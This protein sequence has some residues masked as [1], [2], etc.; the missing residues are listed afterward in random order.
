MLSHRFTNTSVLSFVKRRYSLTPKAFFAAKTNRPPPS[1]SDDNNPSEGAFLIRNPI[2]LIKTLFKRLTSEEI[3]ELHRSLRLL[4]T[5]PSTQK[6]YIEDLEKSLQQAKFALDKN[7]TNHDQKVNINKHSLD[8]LWFQAWL[9][10]VLTPQLPTSFSLKEYDFLPDQQ[11]Q[12][13]LKSTRSKKSKKQMISDEDMKVFPV[14]GTLQ[15]IEKEKA[16][17][18]QARLSAILFDFNAFQDTAFRKSIRK[19]FISDGNDSTTTGATS[20]AANTSNTTSADEIPPPSNEELA[21]YKKATDTTISLF[22]KLTYPKFFQLLQIVEKSWKIKRTHEERVYD[23]DHHT[24]PPTDGTIDTIPTPTTISTRSHSIEL[25]KSI[26]FNMKYDYD[27]CAYILME[28][29]DLTNHELKDYY[30]FTQLKNYKSLIFNELI[31][32]IFH[33]SSQYAL[34]K[35]EIMLQQREMKLTTSSSSSVVSAKSMDI[36]IPSVHEIMN[37]DVDKPVYQRNDETQIDSNHSYKQNDSHGDNRSQKNE[38]AANRLLHNQNFYYKNYILGRRGTFF[39]RQ[40]HF[41]SNYIFEVELQ[42]FNR[43]KSRIGLNY[44]YDTNTNNMLA[45]T[46]SFGLRSNLIDPYTMRTTEGSTRRTY[47]AFNDVMNTSYKDQHDNKV[48]PEIRFLPSS[49]SYKKVLIDNLPPTITVEE[50]KLKLLNFRDLNKNYDT[51][52]NNGL[53][54]MDVEIEIFHNVPKNMNITSSKHASKQV[55]VLKE[56]KTMSDKIDNFGVLSEENLHEDDIEIDN[57]NDEISSEA[58]LDSV[59]QNE[60]RLPEE[61]QLRKLKKMTMIEREALNNTNT[62]NISHSNSAP[63]PPLSSMSDVKKYSNLLKTQQNETSP[64]T[65]EAVESSI[66][67]LNNNNSTV[68]HNEGDLS[69]F[70]ILTKEEEEERKVQIKQILKERNIK[71]EDEHYE[72]MKKLIEFETFEHEN[73]KIIRRNQKKEEKLLLKFQ[74]KQEQLRQQQ[75]VL[76]PEGL[77]SLDDII[78]DSIK[79]LSS[80]SSPSSVSSTESSSSSNKKKDEK[81]SML[82]E[83]AEEE[84]LKAKNKEKRKK[85]TQD[86]TTNDVITP[87]ITEVEGEGE[88]DDNNNNKNS[89]KKKIEL[90]PAKK[91]KK[92]T[93]VQKLQDLEASVSEPIV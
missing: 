40:D 77:P 3:D 27:D 92:L 9:Y 21:N 34:K 49:S 57:K 81:F 36:K 74:K 93:S 61:N 67:S 18:A 59:F 17:D 60:L 5:V 2:S 52:D 48:P 86:N 50:L 71:E 1:S 55:K 11:L 8:N 78:A 87:T 65:T 46:P 13:T 53:I 73:Q 6:K 23:N 31:Q 19:H 22:T 88:K 64:S 56:E 44:E 68:V 7:N 89:K 32:E 51:L 29:F 45:M 4:R 25:L 90:P 79:P 42:L 16:I 85:K 14:Q 28:F 75:Q 62:T 38:N 12:T 72:R 83:Y 15:T 54:N 37:F 84:N 63:L 47:E 26:F 24:T 58:Y 41:S 66:T 82:F 69:R 39:G 30:D 76:I 10:R 20:A 33:L 91:A 70:L 80:S 43:D 35:Q